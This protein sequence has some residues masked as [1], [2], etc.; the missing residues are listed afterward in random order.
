M[1]AF[2]GVHPEIALD[3]QQVEGA[4]ASTEMAFEVKSE[5]DEGQ[6]IV[7]EERSHQASLRRRAHRPLASSTQSSS[8]DNIR[9]F[10][11]VAWDR[12]G[13]SVHAP[14]SADVPDRSRPHGSN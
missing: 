9:R 4:E 5:E 8:L 13:V 3:E 1:G 10:R 6:P 14:A 12:L 7:K 11:G 2:R